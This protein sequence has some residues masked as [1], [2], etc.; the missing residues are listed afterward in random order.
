MLFKKNLPFF[1]LILSLSHAVAQAPPIES[2]PWK[3][4]WIAV[5][6]EPANEYGVYFFRKSFSLAAK[7]SR[8]IIHVSADNRYKLFINGRMV[9][10]GPARGDIYYWN[11]ET[12]DIA[13]FLQPGENTI[14]AIVWNEGPDRPEAQVS[15]RTAFILQ[16]ASSSEDVVN[17]DKTWKGIRDDSHK[18]LPVNIIYTYYV[19]GPGEAVD[20]NA[21]VEG[22]MQNGFNDRDWQNAQQL[23]NGLPKG[24]FAWSSGWMLVPGSI[25]PMELSALRLQKLRRAEGVQVPSSFPAT[26][27][28]VTIPSH[29]TA[30]LL[31]DQ[32][33]LTNAYPSI[34]FSKGK[35]ATISLGY[36][37]ALYLVEKDKTDW[38]AQHQKGNRNEIEGK[39]FVG[40]EDRITS[41][42]KWQQSFTTLW[43]RTYRYLQVKIETGD[44]PLTIDDIYGTFTGYPF[45]YTAKLETDNKLLPAILDIGW[46][47]ARLCAVETYMDC[48]YY[49]QLQYVGDTRIQA[50]VSLYN[51]GDDRLMREAIEL[52]DNS[53]MAEGITLSRYPTATPQQIPP[54][55][56]WWI[57][58]IH[59]Y[60]RYRPDSNFVKHKLSGTRQ[61][62]EFFS[63]YQAKDGSL[64]NVPYWNFTDWAQGKKWD[65]GVAPIGAN[66]HSAALDLQL[67]WAYQIASELETKLGM[68]E[69][70]RK[71]KTAAAQLRTSIRNR[72]WDNAKNLFADTPDKDVFSQHTNTLAIL[73]EVSKDDEAKALAKKIMTDTSL[74]EATIY[75]KYYV[76]AALIKAGFGNDYLNWLN[77]WKEN[78]KQGLTTWAEISD[79]NNARSDCHAWG[80]HPNIEF[81][82]TI[83]GIDANSEGFRTVKIEPHLGALTKISGEI[84]HPK[85]K[86]SVAYLLDTNWK[87]GITL[88]SNTPGIL[89]WEGKKYPLKPG[90]N[91]FRFDYRRR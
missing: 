37:E 27:T 44:E 35:N 86:I 42:G 60:W 18:P 25:P 75:F 1:L 67:L 48:P 91:E 73:T 3:A 43:W 81:F 2:K 31:L 23:S 14:A 24:V 12:V 15:Y 83:L 65:R 82:R 33:F 77:V 49:E 79:I 29:T 61:V 52:L 36:A 59:D 7:P 16:G 13:S 68:Q 70:A 39:R 28:P 88:P 38:R 76:H 71:Y 10:L 63:R 56:L 11:Y 90:R 40:K 4:Y 6:N 26:K 89:V 72:Y 17:T 32:G 62:L 21:V 8:F 55:S 69:Y 53:R 74:T 41:N 45:Q 84:P 5:P 51:S 30:T 9:S 58:M 54:F 22:W 19:A 34:T 46:R 57:G 85:G 78:I 66:G 50:L 80:S 20:M 87:I 47:T 64:V